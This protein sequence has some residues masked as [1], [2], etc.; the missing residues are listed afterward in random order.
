MAPPQRRRSLGPVSPKRIY[1]SLSL[2]L[3]GGASPSEAE[4]SDWRRRLSRG[5]AEYS[6]LWDALENEDTLAVQHLLSRER[7]TEAQVNSVSELG[8]VP[9]DVAALTHNAPLLQVLVKAGGKHNPTLSSTSDW[10]LK[11]EEL[12]SLAE[13]KQEEWRAELLLRVKA[14]LQ[15][16]T[17]VQ[18]NVDLWTRR[19]ELYRRMRDR[20][21][22]TAPP[23]P[24][25]GA[26]LLVM[27]NS[28]VCV[29]V[30]EPTGQTH[31]LITRYRVEWSSSSCFHPLSGTGFI[32]DTRSPEFSITGL[33]TDVQY[34]VRVSAYN[35]RGWG[36][37]VSS[38]PP[39]VAP[40]SWS[41]CCGVTVR[42]RNPA[43][44][45][46]RISLQIREPTLSESRSSVKR[47]CV[48]RGLKQLFH[49]SR[50]VR[51]LQRGVYL[52][53][54]FS[55]KDSVLVTAD[56]QLPL[57]EIQSC[58]RS[59]T[60]DFLWFCKLS[61]AWTQVPRLLQVLSSSS[62]SSSSSLLQNRLSFLRA[63]AQ[64]QASVGCVDLGQVYFEPLKDRQGNVLLVTLRE[65]TTPLTPSDPALHW[66][67]VS[68]LER[69]QSETPLLPEPSAVELL[70]HR[71][72]EM[73]AYHRRSQQRAQPGLYV[74]IL[75]L[76]SSVDQLRILV[77]QRLPNMP[78]HCRVRNRPH[79]SREEW[80]WLQ[81]HAVGG[82]CASQEGGDDAVIDSSGVED[83]VKALRSAVTQLLT[84]LNV[85]L[86]RA[87]EYRVY[88][89][90]LLQVGDQV[91]VI[92]L[93]PPCEEFRSRQRPAEGAQHT[94]TVPM[95]YFELV[96]LWAY[97][98]D[99]LSQ[100]CQLWLR[101]ELDVRLSQQALR[102]ALDTEELQEATERLAH[103]TQ[104]AQS[105]SALW[106][107]SRWL[108][109]VIQTLRSKHSEGAVP[110]GR[111]MTSRPIRSATCE[112]TPPALHT[113]EQM[114]TA[115]VMGSEVSAPVEVTDGV[116]CPE[117]P[118]SHY[119]DEPRSHG[120]SSRRRGSS[121]R[122]M[123]SCPELSDPAA[124]HPI[125]PSDGGQELL[126]E[127]MDLFQSLD[128]LGGSLTDLQ[129]LDWS[130]PEPDLQN[131]EQEDSGVTRRGHPVRSLVEWV[132]STV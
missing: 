123:H 91:C 40:S 37:F 75:K 100:Y 8:L 81:K 101:L 125:M 109:D 49:S 117:T 1:R 7:V 24:P 15:S 14:E 6:C 97:E 119:T 20:F 64:L 41:S 80:A 95:H 13:Q 45:V 130:D 27:S 35:V 72:K 74:G 54:V 128:L 32:T 68:S 111:V 122:Q 99:L 23:G 118:P 30:S 22:T 48:S 115:E 4:P 10:S 110:L 120:S 52:A 46:R 3:K 57:V 105:L 124:S 9:L 104:L 114:H 28:C 132:K 39:C 127:M 90:E 77:P 21:Q 55:Q 129:E 36:P 31:G 51:L 50:F 11:L 17:D 108:M 44:A 29:R 66:L 84:K 63:V 60:Q 131:Q 5:P 86:E 16:Q 65:V 78:C 56:D 71:L 26:V 42:R 88:T 53:S 12:V 89:Q 38:S 33:Q 94:L 19:W 2:K 126:T 62:L 58:S 73:L 59:V 112:D 85:P 103:V 18:K 82:A 25:A 47:V 70:T 116:T 98:R 87:S 121:I 76:C 96:H 79:V 83:F 34:Y 92:L 102:E 69:N 107:E 113:V 61:C 43:A 93:L 67:P 106:R